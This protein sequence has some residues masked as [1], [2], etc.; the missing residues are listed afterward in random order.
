MKKAAMKSP[1]LFLTLFVTITFLASAIVL[2]A[3]DQQQQEEE[4]LRK[5]V[6]EEIKKQFEETGMPMLTGSIW[7]NASRE[8]K[9]A[10][11][12]GI[13]HVITVEKA[14]VEKLPSLKV[15]NFSAKASEGLAG[16]KINDIVSG[17]DEHYRANPSRI[18]VPVVQVIWDALIKP[19]LQTGI[20]GH[21]LQ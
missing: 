12:W 20:A 16:L 3:T 10:F 4:H 13:C 2:A 9:V 21:P 15:E 11:V 17:V 7:Q 5:E 8:N 1:K 19:R 6:K 14:L 18:E